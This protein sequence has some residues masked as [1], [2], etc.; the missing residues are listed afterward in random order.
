MTIA[1]DTFPS[2]LS[3]WVLSGGNPSWI[4]SGVVRLTGD[5]I[6]D[7]PS[8]SGSFTVQTILSFAAVNETAGFGPWGQS[9][10]ST[11]YCPGI[12]LNSAGTQFT[13]MGAAY[14]VASP[15]SFGSWNGTIINVVGV[16]LNIDVTIF[17]K[18]TLGQTAAI[19]T[20]NGVSYSTGFLTTPAY[21][22][23]FFTR[24]Q[25]FTNNSV[26]LNTYA[27]VN[28]R[29]F[30]IGPVT[31]N[32]G[33]TDSD[34]DSLYSPSSS[35]TISS[36]KIKVRP[37]PQFILK[38]AINFIQNSK[39][40]WTGSDRGA[41][42]DIYESYLTF[43]GSDTT[44]NNLNTALNAAR[45]SISLSGFNTDI[46][47][48]NVDQTGSV[49]ASITDFGQRKQLQFN[50][51]AASVFETTVGFRAISPA[52]LSTT[53]SLSSLRLQEGWEGDHSTEIAKGF[54]LTQ[55]ASYADRNSD[56]GKFVGR[57]SQSTT[58]LKAILAYLLVTVRGVSMVFPTL[59]GV[60]YPFGVSKGVGP[61]NVVVYSIQVQ[62]QNLNRWTL[63]LD[64][65]E[66]P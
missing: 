7:R 37:W 15:S 43:Q 56:S 36:A 12:K 28:N 8:L 10:V 62:R 50:G 13:L 6:I 26:Y 1:I 11:N 17:I 59:S 5:D 40:Y 34:I 54:S 14:G 53:P 3:P 39:G 47:L 55:A 21:T 44:I 22:P 35:L 57:F 27:N 51:V 38:P 20:Y 33:L 45:E 32:Y 61:F 19:A 18:A 64:L 46:F 66:A 25:F 2:S 24:F 31:I 9:I 16:N 63:T 49:T 41:A 30:D 42:Q 58:E 60:T 29:I 4:S 65:R 48:P 52:I 23:Y